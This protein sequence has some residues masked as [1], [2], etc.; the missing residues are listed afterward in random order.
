MEHSPIWDSQKIDIM[1]TIVEEK[2]MQNP[3]L[4]DKLVATGQDLLIEATLDIFWA[5]KATLNSKSLKN[6]TWQGANFMGKILME[7][8]TELRR[9]LG[10]ST[11]PTPMEESNAPQQN[12]QANQSRPPTSVG[13]SAVTTTRH[14]P[15]RHLSCHYL[16]NVNTGLG[17]WFACGE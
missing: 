8:R 1:R 3:Y 5:A 17:A 2:F 13:D 14:P 9:E 4:C 7:V 15:T 6:R 16:I 11:E 10:L 12:T